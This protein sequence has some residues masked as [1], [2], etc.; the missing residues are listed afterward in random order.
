VSTCHFNRGSNPVHNHLNLFVG[1]ILRL[2]KLL[3]QPINK[4]TKLHHII[5]INS[6]ISYSSH[7]L[8]VNPNIIA[9]SSFDLSARYKSLRV[10][11]SDHVE[12]L[13]HLHNEA[14]ES[15]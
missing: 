8:A 15:I 11:Y 12:L 7:I 2:R 13:L 4:I 14:F 10:L 5:C 1:A 6:N 3:K 9:D